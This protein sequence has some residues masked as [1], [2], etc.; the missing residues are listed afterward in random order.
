[1][2]GQVPDRRVGPPKNGPPKK[3]TETEAGGTGHGAATVGGPDPETEN[4]PGEC[5]E[6]NLEQ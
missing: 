5:C 3:M 4:E 2:D 1:M 6:L